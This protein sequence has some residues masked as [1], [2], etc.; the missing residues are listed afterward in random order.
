MLF[1]ESS[2]NDMNNNFLLGI[3]FISLTVSF[4]AW[5]GKK[6]CKPLLE[7]LQNIQAQQRQG[8]SVRRG[9]SLQARADKAREKWWQCENRINKPKKKTKIKPSV[10]QKSTLAST[11]VSTKKITPFATS[12]A[13]VVKSRFKGEKQQAWLDYYQ[14]QRPQK[15]KRP[16]TIKIFAFCMEDKAKKQAVFARNYQK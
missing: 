4:S 2:R 8:Y 14:K 16:K 3:F 7:K 12:Q 15:C 6:R 5:S 9:I 10:T 11:D 13:I 1:V